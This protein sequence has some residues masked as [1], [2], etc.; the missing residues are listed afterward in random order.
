MSLPLPPRESMRRAVRSVCWL[1]DARSGGWQP[2]M[3]H[4]RSRRRGYSQGTEGY[5]GSS[6]VPS[7]TR[8]RH[9]TRARSSRGV[10]CSSG[11]ILPLTKALEVLISD[12]VWLFRLLATM[13]HVR[14]A[15]KDV[16]QDLG[17]S[18]FP[19]SV[20][21]SPEEMEVLVFDICIPR[22]PVMCDSTMAVYPPPR[23]LVGFRAYRS[24][25]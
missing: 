25:A 5:A 4:R 16:V 14:R 3:R 12:L 9:R 24:S 1:Q 13:Q 7:C 20:L 8:A 18:R 10:L 6:K 21:Q 11:W 23:E 22:P 2:V 15:Y 17:A 19:L